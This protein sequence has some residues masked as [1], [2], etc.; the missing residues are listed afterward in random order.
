MFSDL[1]ISKDSSFLHTKTNSF[2]CSHYQP[3]EDIFFLNHC[4]LKG[5]QPYQ[6]HIYQKNCI[7]FHGLVIFIHHNTAVA[8]FVSEFLTRSEFADY[9]ISKLH[10]YVLI[11]HCPPTFLEFA[12][13]I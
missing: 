3:L 13:P 12:L 4:D 2:D 10:Y 1:H 9:Y 11:G 8:Y 7:I 5:T 6:H